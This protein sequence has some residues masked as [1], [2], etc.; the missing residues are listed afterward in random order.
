[1]YISFK[2]Y[3]VPKDNCGLPF[4]G[5]RIAYGYFNITD[6][7]TLSVNVEVHLTGTSLKK[8]FETNP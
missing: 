2:L 1:V 4:E 5:Q 7:C 6:I 3:A 8:Q